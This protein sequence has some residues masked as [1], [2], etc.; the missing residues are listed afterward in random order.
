ML[1][2]K[3]TSSSLEMLHKLHIGNSFLFTVNSTKKSLHFL[4]SKLAYTKKV[5]KKNKIKFFRELKAIF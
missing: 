4:L 1:D 2:N 3:L 5:D